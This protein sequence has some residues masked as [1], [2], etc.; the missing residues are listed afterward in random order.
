MRFDEENLVSC[1]GLVP[2][3][4]LAEQAGLSDLVTEHVK[5]TNEPVTSTGTNPA[6]KLSSI[7]A[8]MAAGADSIDDL[9]V[10][11]HGGMTR[12]FTGV[13]AP[14]TLGSFLR[15]FT[16]GHAVQLAAVARRFLISLAARTPILAGADEL[17][18]VDIDSVLRRVYG[19]QKQGA[20]FGHAKVGGYPVRLRGLSLLV[21]T[22]CTPIAAPV[23]AAIRLRAGSAGSCRGA[24]SLL[25]QAL[26]TARAAGAS[27]RLWVRADSAYY[28]GAIVSAAR[29]AGAWFSLTVTMNPAIQ[30]AIA[31]IAED[32]WTPVEYPEAV[33][34]PDTGEWIS[35]AQVAETSY[36]AFAGTRHQIT[37]RLVV[38]RV[39]D[40]NH[41]E[42]LVPVWRY[43]A[44]LTNTAL[45]TVDADLTHRQ[46]A[47]I[48]TT[49]ADL[50]DGPLAHLPSGRFNANAAWAICAAIT[51]NLLRAA[52][53]LTSSFHARARSATLRRHLITVPARLACPQGYPTL[54]LPA[55]WPWQDSWHG[56]YATVTSPP[57]AA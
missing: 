24:A 46:H 6:G 12:L 11:R 49:F 20:R 5:I 42:A 47:I 3:M 26:A 40:N 31:G 44:F 43:H 18:F 57:P 29:R 21:A 19:K 35:D 15:A 4:A 37:A 53:S 36:T 38:R 33:L 9:D 51:H 13:Y 41:T 45:S 50:T 16:H 25:A 14:S 30:A 23:I 55:S 32:A 48:E 28:A 17:T 27:G 52:G 56:L 39:P 10:I 2:V 22:I 54:H 1:A 7:V 34:D 8:G